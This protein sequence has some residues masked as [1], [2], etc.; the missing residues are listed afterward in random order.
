[1]RWIKHLAVLAL[2]AALAGCAADDETEYEDPWWMESE[3]EARMR[4]AR[5]R[6][7]SEVIPEEE[8]DAAEEGP[9]GM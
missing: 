2:L 7:N 8:T 9:A 6:G 4:R 5:Q 3:G 1:M